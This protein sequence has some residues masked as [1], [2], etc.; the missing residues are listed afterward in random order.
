MTDPEQDSNPAVI[1]ARK[2]AARYEDHIADT[3]GFGRNT[4]LPLLIAAPAPI[5]W[6]S[7]DI[8][9]P[10]SAVETPDTITETVLVKYENDAMEFEA[11]AG[12]LMC[13]P[14]DEKMHLLYSLGF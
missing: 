14:S 5:T 3:V 8:P 2:A 7:L 1:E 6:R 13:A 11:R 4:A 12:V 10:L 9:K